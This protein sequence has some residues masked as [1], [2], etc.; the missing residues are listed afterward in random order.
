M[1][2]EFPQLRQTNVVG[3]ARFMRIATCSPFV[4]V[5]TDVPRDVQESLKMTLALIASA[6]AENGQAGSVNSNTTTAQ[7]N[8]TQLKLASYNR[9]YLDIQIG[10][11]SLDMMASQFDQRP[12]YIIANI[13][14]RKYPFL[15]QL[16]L[17]FILLS[18]SS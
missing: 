6:K 1:L 10:K 4:T 9:G 2:L 5:L 7:E 11:K 17:V 18:V 3:L 8:L 15:T 16:M 14:H 13:I 12:Q